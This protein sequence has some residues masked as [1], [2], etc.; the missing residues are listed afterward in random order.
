MLSARQTPQRAGIGLPP[1]DLSAAF[2]FHIVL[3]RE[4]RVVQ[5]GEVILRICPTL[6]VGKKLATAFR[7]VRPSL[8]DEFNLI[9][10]QPRALFM[11]SSLSSKL[12]L[13]GQMLYL[14]DDDV[15]AFLGSPW[16][17]ELPEIQ[18]LGMALDDFAVHDPVA[19]FLFLLQSK[20]TA[21]RDAQVLAN[22]LKRQGEELRVSNFALEEERRLLEDKVRER[23]FELSRANDSLMKKEQ[24][25]LEDLAQARSFQQSIL[26][27]TPRSASVDFAASYLPAGMVGGDIYDID[28]IDRDH[29]RV[30][31]ADATGHGVQASRR[32]MILKSEYEV[33]K[34]TSEDPAR[35]LELLNNRLLSAYL[36]VEL[37][38]TACCLDLEMKADGSARVRLSN[39]A[40]PP[41]LHVSG[42]TAIERGA[43]G[44]FFGLME[45]VQF[46]TLE[47]DLAPD[48]V[49]FAYTDGLTEQQGSDGTEFGVERIARSVADGSIRDAAEAANVVLKE[50]R[51]FLGHDEQADDITLVTMRCPGRG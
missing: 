49:L 48:D 12:L 50:F 1:G 11:L 15:I 42:R 37:H 36:G 6:Q 28:R 16:V 34:R 14:A 17:Q 5:A 10:G 13:K 33:L 20:N 9:R 39:S 24:I 45:N 3:D 38:C 8:A 30:F 51:E 35:L 25:M 32:T 44:P 18:T 43:I 41:L 19:D 40:H 27:R 4:L 23:T 26:P 29:F 7:V 2:P 46:P 47:F 31:V 21:L 22:Q